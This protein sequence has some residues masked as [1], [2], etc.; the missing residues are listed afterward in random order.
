[1]NVRFLRRNQPLLY[2]P[3]KDRPT[4]TQST[5]YPNSKMTFKWANW[6]NHQ[7]VSIAELKTQFMSRNVNSLRTSEFGS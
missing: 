6:G 7:T 3:P 2:K 4:S 1:M 5:S